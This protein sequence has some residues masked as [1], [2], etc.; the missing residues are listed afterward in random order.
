MDSLSSEPVRRVLGR[1]GLLEFGEVE[2][3]VANVEKTL[4]QDQLR[5]L[6]Q[7][8][9]VCL[10]AHHRLMVRRIAARIGEGIQEFGVLREAV[11]LPRSEP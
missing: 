5:Y 6:A 2:D 9:V 10:E 1:V 8:L 11:G 4:D 3:A 7:F